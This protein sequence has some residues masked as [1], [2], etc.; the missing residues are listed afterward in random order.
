MKTIVS[1]LIESPFYFTVPLR[2]RYGLIRRLRE[3]E[4]RI[5]LSGYQ[6]KVNAFLEITMPNL[7]KTPPF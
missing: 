5:D 2:D 6:E 3:K 4:K 1:V 7:L